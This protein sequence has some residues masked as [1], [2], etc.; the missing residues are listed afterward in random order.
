MAHEKYQ[1][2]IDECIKC[3]VQCN[4]CATECLNEQDAAMLTKCIQLDRDCAVI[5][6]AAVDYMSRGSE[7]APQVCA[8]CADICD[9]CAEECEKHAKMEH[10]KLCAEQCRKCAEECRKLATIVA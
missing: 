2:C 6:L 4:H 7:N 9:A 8:I 5:C 3:A 10:C 1:S